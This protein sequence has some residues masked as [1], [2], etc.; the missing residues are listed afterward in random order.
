M[1]RSGS[2]WRVILPAAWRKRIKPR[3]PCPAH[4]SRKDGMSEARAERP[5]CAMSHATA[6]RLTATIRAVAADLPPIDTPSEPSI[7]TICVRL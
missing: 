1:A 6:L 5:N 4:V 7:S 3:E 2:G